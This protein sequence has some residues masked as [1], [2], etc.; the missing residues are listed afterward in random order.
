[1]NDP[2]VI[3][4]SCEIVEHLPAVF[5][6]VYFVPAVSMDVRTEIVPTS[7]APT[8]DVTGKRLLSSVD[9]HVPPEVCCSDE[10]PSTDVTWEGS[11][12]LQL[13]TF[14]LSQVVCLQCHH[15]AMHHLTQRGETVI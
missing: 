13:S 10:L 11:L 4:K 1:M 8:T 12:G 15:L 14:L 5:T 2:A 3:C 7:V 9:P 6:L